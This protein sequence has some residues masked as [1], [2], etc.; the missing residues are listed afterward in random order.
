MARTTKPERTIQKTGSIRKWA[1]CVEAA[2]KR[3]GLDYGQTA[4][5][6]DITLSY[7]AVLR[8]G[9]NI[10]QKE[11]G[12]DVVRRS[13]EL[14]GTSVL[15]AYLLVG[16]LQTEDLYHHVDKESELER[17]YSKM[18]EDVSFSQLIPTHD[19]WVA[20]SL[21]TRYGL[22]ILFEVA[23]RKDLFEKAALMSPDT[24][25]DAFY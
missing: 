19:E 6:L 23:T 12:T 9:G 8:G 14:L 5:Y 18:R 24:T 25:L 20:L 1:Q 3:Q 4:E 7:W 17:A 16:I 10:H 21:N 2:A 13:A 22:V 15:D 11:V